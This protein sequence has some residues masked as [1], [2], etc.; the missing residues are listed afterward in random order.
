MHSIDGSSS[1][2]VR[3]TG[4]DDAISIALQDGRYAISDAGNPF[5]AS[6]VEECDAI[7][8]NAICDADV[9]TI[10]IDA[11]GGNDQVTVAET[12]PRRSKCGSKAVPAPTG[13]RAAPA[14]T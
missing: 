10:L 3:G 1:L 13:S 11:G 4:A 14:T 12:S 6:N 5:P 7:A 2:S 9:R 8:G